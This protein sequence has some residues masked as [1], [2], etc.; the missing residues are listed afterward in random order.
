MKQWLT[1]VTDQHSMKFFR[2][3]VLLNTKSSELRSEKNKTQ[4]SLILYTSDTGS[5]YTKFG[6]NKK[7]V[8]EYISI[9]F[10]KIKKYYCVYS[11]ICWQ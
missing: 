7:Y 4:F 1:C 11:K 8:F 3:L 6:K 5:N 10:V 2:A 9:G